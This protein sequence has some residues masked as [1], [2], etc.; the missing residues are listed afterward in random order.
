MLYTHR[1]TATCFDHLVVIRRLSK[2]IKLKLKLKIAVAI[3]IL[4]V[5]YFDG[6]PLTTQ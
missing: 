6:L 4:I 3:A 5:R 1:C 2:H